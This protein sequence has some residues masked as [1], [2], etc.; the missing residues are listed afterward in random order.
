MTK[1]DKEEIGSD[2]WNEGKWKNFV[3]PFLPKDGAGLSLIDMGCNAGLFLSFAEDKGFR[4]GGIDSSESAVHRGNVWAEKN[5][6]DY[7]IVYGKMEKAI[8]NLPIIDYTIFVNAHYYITVNDFLEYLDKLKLKSRYCIIVTDKKNH[9]NRCWASADVDDIRSYFRDWEEAGFI[10]ELP[11]KGK[12]ARRLKS[13]M[14]KSRHLDFTPIAD[15]DSSNH[16]QDEFC[17]ELDEGKHYSET[18][19]YRIMKPY[20]KNWSKERLNLWFEE[21]VKLYEDIKENGLKEPIIID[22]KNEIVDG[23]HRYAIMRHLGDKDIYVKKI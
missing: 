11:Q 17:A 14:F 2:F 18:K 23:N 9:V 5:G 21:R 6:Y 20:R 7:R 12:H 22:S 3:E 10:D 15:L 8:D 19:Y 4:A 16:V 13:L 1:R